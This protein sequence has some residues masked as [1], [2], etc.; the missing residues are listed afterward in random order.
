MVA[1]VPGWVV[2]NGLWLNLSFSKLFGFL[3]MFMVILRLNCLHD[4][5]AETNYRE[6]QDTLFSALHVFSTI[7]G[8]LF[9]NM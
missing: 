2:V 7:A 3:T 1:E 5:E 6:E 4:D 9:C 8:S